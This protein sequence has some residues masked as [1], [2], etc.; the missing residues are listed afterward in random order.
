[1]A[2]ATNNTWVFFESSLLAASVQYEVD[3]LSE[4]GLVVSLTHID[5]VRTGIVDPQTLQIWHDYRGIPLFLIEVRGE[6]MVYAVEDVIDDGQP[7][8]KI[9]IMFAGARV[10]GYQSVSTTWDGGD[11][12]LWQDVVLPRCRLHFSV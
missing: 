8:I 12:S 5:K 9:S 6:L 7:A 3:A 11:E 1:M 2:Y 4:T 10:R